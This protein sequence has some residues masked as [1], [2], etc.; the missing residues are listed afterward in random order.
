VKPKSRMP[1]MMS[2]LLPSKKF[3]L[4]LSPLGVNYT[5]ALLTMSCVSCIQ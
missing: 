1:V 3:F 2:R 5:S 4:F